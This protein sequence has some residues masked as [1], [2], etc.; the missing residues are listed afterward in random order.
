MT[1]YSFPTSDYKANCMPKKRKIVNP[2]FVT[3]YKKLAMRRTAKMAVRIDE[4]RYLGTP[5]VEDS[6]YC[7]FNATRTRFCSNNVRGEVN[8]TVQTVGFGVPRGGFHCSTDWTN[9][10]N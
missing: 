8:L 2:F 5:F 1:A 9:V 3:V 4:K 7:V 6:I 10:R